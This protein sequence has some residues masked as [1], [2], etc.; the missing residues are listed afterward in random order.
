[1]ARIVPPLKAHHE[2]GTFRKPV[3]NLTLAFVT[4]LGTDD[5]NICHS[6]QT[7]SKYALAEA[8]SIGH[9][10]FTIN[11]FRQCERNVKCALKLTP[12]VETG[13]CDKADRITRSKADKFVHFQKSTPSTCANHIDLE[14]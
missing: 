4:P 6:M 7:L 13:L 2:I 11:R 1:M 8:I 9:P 3:D 10:R 12:L 5:H 14:R